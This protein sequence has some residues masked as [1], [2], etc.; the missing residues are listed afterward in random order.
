MLLHG[1]GIIFPPQECS[2]PLNLIIKKTNKIPKLKKK[3]VLLFSKHVPY[4]SHNASGVISVPTAHLVDSAFPAI[5]NCAP[6]SQ[7][8]EL[9]KN[10]I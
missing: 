2:P 7:F 1:G 3:S 4:S 9:L 8:C 6:P 5:S 10:N